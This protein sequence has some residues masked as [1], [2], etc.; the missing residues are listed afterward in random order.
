MKRIIYK[1]SDGGVSVITPAPDALAIY[2]INTI[3]QKDVPAGLPY[4]IIDDTD[5]PSTRVFRCAWEVDS[6][7]KVKTNI[8]KAQAVAHDKRR[9]KRSEEFKPLDIEATI[10]SKAVKAEEARQLI[11]TKYD[12]IQSEIDNCTTIEDLLLT[13]NR[14][15]LC[16]S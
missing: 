2:G 6:Q 11:R 12:S 3:A 15:Q 7:L 16:N 13:V 9:A 10:P 5:L 8:N 1:N 4:K 14:Y